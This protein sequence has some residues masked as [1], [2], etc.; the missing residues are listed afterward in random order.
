MA[1]F[2]RAEPWW[3]RAEA[4]GGTA[5]G[6]PDVPGHDASDH[7]LPDYEVHDEGSPAD[8]DLD[9]RAT[10]ERERWR[11]F[12]SAKPRLAADGIRALS[13]RGDI[14]TSWWSRRFLKAIESPETASRLSRGK[15]YARSGQVLSL[16]VAPGTVTAQVQGS[17]HQPYAVT[18]GV[19]VFSAADWRRAVGALAQQ[20]AYSAELLAGRMP[21]DVEQVLEP[22]GLSLFP[23]IRQLDLEC[24]CPDWGN[25]CKHAAA[26]CFLLAEQFDADPF[27]IL[28]WRG[29]ARE[30]LLKALRAQRAR[31]TVGEAPEA[32]GE[33]DELRGFWTGAALPAPPPADPD[34]ASRLLARLGPVG[35]AVAGRDFAKALAPAYEAMVR[36]SW[37][38]PLLTGELPPRPTSAAAEPYVPSDVP[39]DTAPP[40]ASL[41]R[42]W[43]REQGIEVNERGRLRADLIRAYRDANP[44]D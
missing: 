17:R 43:A 3:K 6:T 33:R 37:T 9:G 16:A 34:A 2:K 29:M 26:V 7:D 10:D 35:V 11:G 14:A 25:P 22:L 13:R 23:G 4:D 28:R 44:L 27:T 42:A 15:S 12:P 40:M 39:R 18:V 32:T 1:A 19:A 8:A 30:D 38:S 24:S 31:Q 41:V 20:A 36:H 5:P 21:E